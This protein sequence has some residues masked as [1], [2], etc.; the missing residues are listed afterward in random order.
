MKKI[1]TNKWT[2]RNPQKENSPANTTEKK[3][4]TATQE[5]Q[6]RAWTW[7]FDTLIHYK[8]G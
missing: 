3:E 4:Q 8:I 2:A 6:A 7:G 1:T 5:K